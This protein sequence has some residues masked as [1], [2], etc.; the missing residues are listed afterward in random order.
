MP[1]LLTPEALAVLRVVAP[2]VTIPSLATAIVDAL[3]TGRAVVPPTIH[4]SLRNLPVTGPDF[5]AWWAIS[6]AG[7]HLPQAEVTRY[8]KAMLDR[9]T[10]SPQPPR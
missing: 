10:N 4:Q 2:R 7:W 3:S 5:A 9:F 6:S 8:L 1:P